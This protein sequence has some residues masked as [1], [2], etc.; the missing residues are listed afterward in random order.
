MAFTLVHNKTVFG[1]LRV[2]VIN[3]TTDGAEEAIYT[4]MGFVTGFAV[5]KGSMNSANQHFYKN[6][7]T[8]GTA[9]NGYIACTGF[10]SGD[11]FDLIV[12]GH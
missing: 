4:G 2:N 12:Y 1:N 8:T 7:G 5:G 3:V 10:T 11:A 9:L 6:K